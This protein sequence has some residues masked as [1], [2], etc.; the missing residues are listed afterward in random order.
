MNQRS[1]FIP[2]IASSLASMLERSKKPALRH[3][4]SL[5]ESSH[6]SQ[7][8]LFPTQDTSIVKTS[9]KQSLWRIAQKGVYRPDAS[10]NLR[11]L[12]SV[13]NLDEGYSALEHATLF[14]PPV[15]EEAKY[16][17][18]DAESYDS[19]LG[20]EM[21]KFESLEIQQESDQE[22]EQDEE[23]D[24]EER[25]SLLP[26]IEETHTNP[27]TNMLD[28]AS[29]EDEGEH[30]ELDTTDLDD[31]IEADQTD[32]YYYISPPASQKFF[33]YNYQPPPPSDISEMLTSDSVE[34][35]VDDPNSLPT[36]VT[37]ISI[38]IDLGE[39]IDENND[40]MLCNQL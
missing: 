32:A 18:E 25:H 14:T 21:D 22:E 24:E 23:Q 13:S 2:S 31:T 5:L 34:L 9:I 36:T 1:Q 15:T 7:P 19:Y 17:D 35:D 11:P 16:I 28:N 12:E 29:N 38:D 8:D 26:A 10:R 37:P 30:M 27:S 20:S 39:M 40:D 6:R 33:S 4:I 3:K